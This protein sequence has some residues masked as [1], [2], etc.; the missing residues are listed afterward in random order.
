MYVDRR[1]WQNL[2][3]SISRLCKLEDRGRTFDVQ[4]NFR[5]AGIDTKLV[6]GYVGRIWRFIPPATLSSCARRKGAARPAIF[7]LD[8]DKR[9]ISFVLFARFSRA[10]A[11]QSTWQFDYTRGYACVNTTLLKYGSAIFRRSLRERQKRDGYS[12]E[13]IWLRLQILLA[14]KYQSLLQI[15]FSSFPFLTSSVDIPRQN[16]III[17]RKFSTVGIVTLQSAVYSSPRCYTYRTV[18]SIPAIC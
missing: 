5:R 9:A 2:S 3:T 17:Q 1:I 13:L 6:V 12:V 8:R 4:L 7:A 14:E 15:F 11:K 16:G 10:N 18:K